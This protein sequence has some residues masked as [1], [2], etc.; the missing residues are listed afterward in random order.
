LRRAA[1]YLFYDFTGQVDDYVLHTLEH[2]RPHVDHVF[3]VSNSPLGELARERLGGVADT[4]WERENVGLDV[5]AYKTAMEQLGADELAQ[6]DELILMNSTFF[7]PVGTFDA[8]FADMDAR[9]VDFWGITE[10]GF[11]ET[12]PFDHTISMDGHLQ[13][14]WLAVR[15]SM[16]TSEDWATYWAEMPMITSYRAS[17]TEHE[18]RFTGYFEQ[19]GHRS[20]VAFPATDYDTTHPVM[21]NIVE[22]LRDGCP[23]VKR[24]TFFHS[25]MYNEHFAIDGGQVAREMEERGYPMDLLFQNL[26]RTS[27]PRAL[28]TNLGLLEVL[29]EVD[30][31]YD[32]DRPLRVVAVAHIFYPDMTDEI[33]DRLDFLPGDYDLVVTTSDEDKR[34]EISKT[35]ATRGRPADVRVV[36]SNRGRDISAFLVDCRDVIESDDYDLLVKVHSKKNTQDSSN[37]AAQFK[38]HLF[39]GLLSSPGYAANVLRLFQQH[40]TL[41]M[42]FPP[43]YHIGYPTL[44]HSW[45]LN[46][47]RAEQEA[48][49]L[50]IGVPF[51]DTT[52]LSPNGSMF[53]ARPA[54]LRPI[55]AGDYTHDDFPDESGY[56]DGALTHVLER[57]MSYSVLST[58]HHVR[59]VTNADL[60]A[61]NYKFLE[62]RAIAIGELLPAYPNDQI[63]KIK[64]LKRFKVRQKRAEKAAAEAAAAARAPAAAAGAR[65]G[66][67]ARARRR[68]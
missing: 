16:F 24:R 49:R 25:P 34:D 3:V 7:G 59:E 37:I 14:H 44:G 56:G 45:F 42:V 22:M 35:L 9:D 31:G 60:V 62:Y 8:L 68:R 26:A 28:V 27:K 55:A 23:I 20:A 57:L 18:S 50:G 46:K 51:D 6:Y 4:V 19:R 1:F 29:P 64:H 33:V 5:W 40:P 48:A 17:V 15:R 53:I 65:P 39:E 66:L 52:P 32:H 61:L 41:G 58:G 67:L 21:N 47:P 13:S 38:R 63:R 11:A 10:H 36:G 43:L 54:T 30:L 12:H 2:L